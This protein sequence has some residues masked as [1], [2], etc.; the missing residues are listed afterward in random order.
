MNSMHAKSP[1]CREGIRRFGERRRQ[2]TKCGHTWRIRRKKRGRKRKRTTIDPIVRFLKHKVPSLRTAASLR[3]RGREEIRRR[4]ER[5]LN[6]LLAHPPPL[7]DFIPDDAP[8]IIIA[9]GI[10]LWV[11]GRKWTIYIVLLRSVRS[12]T[13]IILPPLVMKGHECGDGWRRALAAIGRERLNR[14]VALVS[15][16]VWGLVNEAHERGWVIQCCHFH[17]LSQFQNYAT[18]GPRS[19]HQAFA[20]ALL[21]KAQEIVT[22]TSPRRLRK[23]RRYFQA[24]ARRSRSRGLRRISRGVL[25]DLDEF[26][27]FLDHPELNLPNTSN[28]AESMIRQIRGLFYRTRGFRSSRSLNRWVRAL[29][30]VKPTIACKGKK[31]TK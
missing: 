19:K 13:A 12:D 17:L 9:D 5:S 14:V 20:I 26:R 16:G 3:A 1:C 24:L 11:R 8:L 27:S 6:Y 29:S 25:R 23:L 7:E 22:T 28:A 30:I 18:T 31:S 4:Y 15:D 2:C 21:R 10:W